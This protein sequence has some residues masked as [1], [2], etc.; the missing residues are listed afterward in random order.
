MRTL[1]LKVFPNLR[2]YLKN[3][4]RSGIAFHTVLS[5]DS[6]SLKCKIMPNARAISPEGYYEGGY[7]TL[8]CY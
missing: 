8:V 6:L 2:K 3:M 4:P 1:R 7:T 5:G